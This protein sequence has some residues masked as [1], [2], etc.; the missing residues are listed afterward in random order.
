MVQPTLQQFT[1]PFFFAEAVIIKSSCFDVLE[2]CAFSAEVENF[3]QDRAL[4]HYSDT[5]CH[6]AIDEK[7][8]D[9]EWSSNQVASENTK[10]DTSFDFCWWGIS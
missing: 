9:G 10:F 7:T 2:N 3:Q 4:H 5:V 6:H 1:G 8:S